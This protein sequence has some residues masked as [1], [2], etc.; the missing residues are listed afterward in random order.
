MNGNILAG[1]K[2][3][4]L[5]K[6]VGPSAPLFHFEDNFLLNKVYCMKLG[7]DQGDLVSLVRTDYCQGT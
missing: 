2:K 1:A 4:C 6:Y 3:K 7:G 5:V